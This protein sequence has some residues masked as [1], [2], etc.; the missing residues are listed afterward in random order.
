[1]I[2]DIDITELGVALESDKES[3]YSGE[4]LI[5]EQEIQELRDLGIK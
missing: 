2:V 5:V 4:I 1:M 3:D